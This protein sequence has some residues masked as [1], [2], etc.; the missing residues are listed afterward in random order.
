MAWV[1]EDVSLHEQKHTHTKGKKGSCW[2][3]GAEREDRP[4]G[5]EEERRQDTEMQGCFN[6][7]SH[8]EKTLVP[9]LTFSLSLSLSLHRTEE[10]GEAEAEGWWGVAGRNDIFICSFKGFLLSP[11]KRDP[12]ALSLY[13][14]SV[15]LFLLSLSPTQWIPIEVFI[16]SRSLSLSTLQY[17]CMAD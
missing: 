14:S 13:F 2:E 10:G 15:V 4:D 1:V 7:R 3:G 17:N 12:P 9:S 11:F 16:L 6:K 8:V 5:E